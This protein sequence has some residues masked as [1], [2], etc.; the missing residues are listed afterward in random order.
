MLFV[1]RLSTAESLEN[2]AFNRIFAFH[3][4]L[5]FDIISVS[6]TGGDL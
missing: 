5:V 3:F 2:T 1:N 4:L 6:K